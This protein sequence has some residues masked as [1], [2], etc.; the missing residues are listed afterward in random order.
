M[1]LYRKQVK[2]KAVPV[3]I[4]AA[5]KRYGDAWQLGVPL[6]FQHYDCI[7]SDRKDFAA[8]ALMEAGVIGRIR[9]SDVGA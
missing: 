7:T 8:M 5:V 6:A 1:N 3:S 2:A 4:V 9:P